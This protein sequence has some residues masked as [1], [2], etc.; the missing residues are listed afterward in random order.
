ML[1]TPVRYP[2]NPRRIYLQM[3]S[4][5]MLSVCKQERSKFREVT[6]LLRSLQVTYDEQ[7]RGCE[8]N[9]EHFATASYWKHNQGSAHSGMNVLNSLVD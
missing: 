1:S 9:L 4:L 5:C 2:C 7:R 6:P 8:P 3:K